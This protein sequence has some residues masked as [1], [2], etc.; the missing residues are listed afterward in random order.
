MP[1]GSRHLSRQTSRVMLLFDGCYYCT[2]LAHPFE[3]V[4]L[5][6]MI[7]RGEEDEEEEEESMRKKKK[8]C[9]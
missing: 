5:R 9:T 7:G 2:T 8:R 6:K 4:A 1:G 3:V